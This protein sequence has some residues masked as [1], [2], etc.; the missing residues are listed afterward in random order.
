MAIPESAL[1][2]LA[3]DDLLDMKHIQG[4][5]NWELF[6]SIMQENPYANAVHQAFLAACQQL[7]V[8]LE[9]YAKPRVVNIRTVPLEVH[10][11][12]RAKSLEN[13]I[14]RVYSYR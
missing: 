12:N 5:D 11:Q 14:Y 1:A 3:Y 4:S 6:A 8:R 2:T 10:A 9:T 13:H 7:G